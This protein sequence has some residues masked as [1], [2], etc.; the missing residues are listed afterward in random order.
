MWQRW[1]QPIL[2]VSALVYVRDK[3]LE[4][5]SVGTP[6]RELQVGRHVLLCLGVVFRKRK[7]Q[8]KL[9]LFFF[10][11]PELFFFFFRSFAPK[12][13]RAPGVGGSRTRAVSWFSEVFARLGLL[14]FY[15]LK[16]K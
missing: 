13:P 14:A 5:G 10:L 3:Q 8:E 6:L 4:S 16:E 15:L 9:F 7:G 12:A 2:L 1:E 11:I